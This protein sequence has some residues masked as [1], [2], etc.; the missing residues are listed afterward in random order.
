MLLPLNQ[1]GL[2]RFYLLITKGYSSFFMWQI[3]LSNSKC[4]LTGCCISYSALGYLLF[5]TLWP[6]QWR[7]FVLPGMVVIL[8][9]WYRALRYSLSIKGVLTII[10]DRREVYWQKQR[11]HF[12]HKPLFLPSALLLALQSQ[13]NQACITLLLFSDHTNNA[14]WRQLCFLMGWINSDENSVG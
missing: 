1:S 9:E 3:P 7:Y 6:S 14:A 4:Q 11:W 8:I 5:A 13:K 2:F 12:Y 10:L